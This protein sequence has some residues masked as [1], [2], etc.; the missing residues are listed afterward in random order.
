MASSR[1]ERIV[2][3]DDTDLVQ[4]VV[5]RQLERL[6]FTVLR[7]TDGIEGLERIRHDAP[8]LV[9]C[10]IRMPRLDGLEL[11]SV[12]RREAPELPV[13]VMSGAGVL[14]DAIGALKLGAWDYITKPVD[15]DALEHAVV[16]A[17]ERVAL[18]R[19][20]RRYRQE[21]EELNQQLRAG[22]RLLA[23]DE[24]AGRQLQFRMLP[25]NN[26]HFGHYLLT[27]EL[28]PS[29]FLSG[30][31]IDAFRIDQEHFGFY[32]ADVAGHGV[33]SALVTVLL[34][35]FVQRQLASYERTGDSMILSPSRL[36]MRLNDDIARDDL[37]K[38]LTIFYGVVDLER[39]SLRYSTAGHF[40]WPVLFD[41]RET[42]VLEHPSVPV[43]ML[44]GTRYE[45]HR[46]ELGAGHR[47]SLFSDGLLAL[48]P[49]PTIKDKLAFLRDYFGRPHVSV[50][51]AREDLHLG[52][53]A[54]LPDDVALLIIQRGDEHGHGHESAA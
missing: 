37:G 49:Q 40:P 41:G 53:S 17:L 2:V 42:R 15:S 51:A 10:D 26:L 21:L 45:E 48:L 31:F 33:A 47:L 25:K 32:L 35:T 9:L 19:E 44:A 34:R 36:L 1:P 28:M 39:D 14:Q 27:R 18:L 3:I 11:L 20:N 52:T 29:Q 13:V 23:E 12:V 7:A 54:T 38:H 6:G 8:D 16:R 24:A 5:T 22:L 4:K 50:E 43:G 30:D 46:V